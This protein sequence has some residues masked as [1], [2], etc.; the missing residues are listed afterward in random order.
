MQSFKD[1]K[2][3][4]DKPLKAVHSTD[5]KV[6]VTPEKISVLHKEKFIDYLS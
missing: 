2:S 4:S 5:D 3:Y 6:D 1:L